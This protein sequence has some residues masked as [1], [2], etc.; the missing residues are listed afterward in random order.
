MEALDP[1]PGTKTANFFRRYRSVLLDFTGHRDV[2][3]RFALLIRVLYR[4]GRTLFSEFIGQPFT[5]VHSSNC[6]RCFGTNEPVP[7]CDWFPTGKMFRG[8][9]KP[10]VRDENGND[11]AKTNRASDFGTRCLF[12]TD[13]PSVSGCL[14]K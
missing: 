2:R 8:R 14:V 11:D 1:R 5:D 7:I 12:V 10:F 9:W 4:V 13:F 6:I 3:L